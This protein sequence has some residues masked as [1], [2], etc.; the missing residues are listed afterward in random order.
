MQLKFGILELLT[1]DDHHNSI[2][3]L[4]TPGFMITVIYGKSG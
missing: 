3:I 2:I 4:I 1:V